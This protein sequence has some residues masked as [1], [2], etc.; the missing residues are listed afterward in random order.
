MIYPTNPHPSCEIDSLQ[1]EERREQERT[2]PQ[3]TSF[4][5]IG[6]Y[7]MIYPMQCSAWRAV[8]KNGV[9]PSARHSRKIQRYPFFLFTGRGVDG[10]LIENTTNMLSKNADRMGKTGRQLQAYSK[11][12]RGMTWLILGAIVAVFIAWLMMYFIIR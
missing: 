10:Q 7:K 2:Y 4:N 9:L 6:C 11:T 8:S 12:S 3:N 5:I 1:I